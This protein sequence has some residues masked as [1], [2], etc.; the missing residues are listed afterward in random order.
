M[1]FRSVSQSRY[2]G[3]TASKYLTFKEYNPE[4]TELDEVTRQRGEE[5]FNEA[6]PVADRYYDDAKRRMALSG[7]IPIAK[8]TG[9]DGKV[10]FIIGP[11]F[12]KDNIG[13]AI[14]NS[15]KGGV[16]FA[17]A[18]GVMAKT[19]IPKGYNEEVYKVQRYL[20]AGSVIETIWGDTS[21]SIL[22]SLS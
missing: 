14:R 15:K 12:N 1:L 4:G 11:S 19:R 8:V 21:N 7:E 3:E 13:D 5:L 9:E 6:Q 2:E 18:A 20:E 10:D 17:D 22:G 16:S